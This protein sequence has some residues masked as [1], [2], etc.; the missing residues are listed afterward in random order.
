[1]A[2]TL[3]RLLSKESPK[4]KTQNTNQINYPDMNKNIFPALLLLCLAML[5]AI[6]ACKKK[7]CSSDYISVGDQCVCPE[8]KFEANGKCR[9]LKPNE[10][11]ASLADCTCQDSIFFEITERT[12]SY[13]LVKFDLGWGG[14]ERT[15]CRLFQMP[16]G[17]SIYTATGSTFTGRLACPI[18]GKIG[19]TT[20]FGRFIENDTKIRV[21]LKYM[22]FPDF[23]E[24]LGHCN[25]ILHQ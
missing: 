15:G 2:G 13:I 11:Y 22:R 23:T 4:L 25:F 1:L 8:G 20:I 18:D 9:D 3:A 6:A 7:Q 14:Y 17:D 12:D 21:T 19:S 16:D 10:Y 5:A 24:E